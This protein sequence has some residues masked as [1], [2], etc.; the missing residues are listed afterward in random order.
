[1]ARGCLFEWEPFTSLWHSDLDFSWSTKVKNLVEAVQDG[2]V[3]SERLLT[4]QC[5]ARTSFNDRCCERSLAIRSISTA[6][7]SW[8]LSVPEALL[9]PSTYASNGH[10]GASLPL[11]DLLPRL[12]GM[13]RGLAQEVAADEVT[14]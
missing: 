12:Y 8:K 11:C 9:G 4:E 3:F 7:C 13:S 6:Q 5:R 1:M 14:P 10:R 2:S